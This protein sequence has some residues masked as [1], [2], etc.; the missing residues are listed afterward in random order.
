MLRHCA[1]SSDRPS[2]MRRLRTGTKPIS[3]SQVIQNDRRKEHDGTK[4]KEDPSG[5]RFDWARSTKFAHYFPLAALVIWIIKYQKMCP[6][7]SCISW[8]TRIMKKQ[9][10]RRNGKCNENFAKCSIYR[11]MC[12]SLTA[13]SP[14]LAN[15]SEQCQKHLSWFRS[16]P[17]HSCEKTR[18]K[19]AVIWFGPVWGL[20]TIC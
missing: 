5:K 9:L 10:E 13:C 19:Y 1:F 18:K 12:W 3:A 7:T 2:F 11:R 6:L 4:R 8:T 14:K 17:W 16:G 20:S 15:I